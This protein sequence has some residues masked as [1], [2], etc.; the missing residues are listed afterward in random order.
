MAFLLDVNVLIALFDPAHIHHNSARNWFAEIGQT[1]WATCPVTENGVVSHYR[2]PALSKLPGSP[3][4][5]ASSLAIFMSRSRHEFW[6]DSISLM[7]S[8]LIRR[9][10]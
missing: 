10:C 4:A 9:G 1:A 7:K 3:A 8:N 6:R 2:R 5:I